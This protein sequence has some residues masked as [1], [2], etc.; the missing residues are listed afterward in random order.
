MRY[1]YRPVVFGRIVVLLFFLSILIFKSFSFAAVDLS[2]DIAAL[3]EEIKAAQAK[4]DRAKAGDTLEK[5]TISVSIKNMQKILGSLS[6]K[7]SGDQN[8][9][10]KVK[11]LNSSLNSLEG[12]KN[13]ND[14]SGAQKILNDMAGAVV[15][16]EKE[17]IK[18][19]P[20][21]LQKREPPPGKVG[22]SDTIARGPGV[23]LVVS[24]V[25]LIHSSQ[26]G[27]PRDSLVIRPSIKICGGVVY[28]PKSVFM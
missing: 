17:T 28:L 13:K 3:K 27:K 10:G 7:A 2:K 25:E 6:Q 23:D 8:L 14:K 4:I 15:A 19:P 12:A 5:I 18:L 1:F 20:T 11:N 24:S 26:L 21:A 9:S 16:L 22:G